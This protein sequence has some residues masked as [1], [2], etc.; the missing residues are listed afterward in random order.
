MFNDLENNSEPIPL[1]NISSPILEV[2]L[3]CNKHTSNSQ[4]IMKELMAY[5]LKPLFDL[6]NAADYL[7]HEKLVH[8]FASIIGKKLSDPASLHDYEDVAWVLQ[9]SSPL[10]IENLHN[11][12]F[13]NSLLQLVCIPDKISET[14]LTNDGEYFQIAFGPGDQT[15]IANGHR[16]VTVWDTN[17]NTWINTLPRLNNDYHSQVILCPSAQIAAITGPSVIKLYDVITNNCIL[18]LTNTPAWVKY[19]DFSPDGKTFAFS[20]DYTT[21][22]WSTHTGEHLHTLSSTDSNHFFAFS[23]DGKIIANCTK[24]A[25]KLWNVTTGS[26]IHTLEIS[27]KYIDL[28]VDLKFSPDGQTLATSSWDTTTK[29]WNVITGECIYTLQ[30]HSGGIEDIAF[31]PNGQILATSSVD[32]T[33]KLWDVTTGECLQTLN[34]FKKANRITFSPDSCILASSSNNI[35]Q[36]WDTITGNYIHTISTHTQTIQSLAFSSNNHILASASNSTIKLHPIRDQELL[37]TYCSLPLEQ[38]LLLA[39]CHNAHSHHIPFNFSQH[40]YLNEIYE[41]CPDT[42]RTRIPDLK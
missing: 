16:N 33:I 21:Q 4:S 35:I 28:I 12:S 41:S 6:F 11:A 22:L 40:A 7:D 37:N 15:L 24:K 17:S 18:T 20:D 13:F 36:L 34:I 14:T 39:F 10:L 30:G 38:L 5:D 25:I 9:N 19:F 2:L 42:V 29:L 27:D 23:P 31:S 26:C 8:L 3:Y 32:Q 1:P